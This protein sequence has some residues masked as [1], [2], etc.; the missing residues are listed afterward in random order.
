M[1]AWEKPET[2]EGDIDMGGSPM[3]AAEIVAMLV[4]ELALHGWE[5]ARSPGQVFAL[6][7]DTAVFLLDVVERYA[8]MYRRYEGF[9][10]VVDVPADAPAIDRALASARNLASPCAASA[11]ARTSSTDG[12]STTVSADTAINARS[13]PR[14]WGTPRATRPSRSRRRSP[15]LRPGGTRRSIQATC[16]CRRGCTTAL[17][18]QRRPC[19]SGM[20]ASAQRSSESRAHR[21]EQRLPVV[22]ARR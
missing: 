21:G 14:S 3:P 10:A 8:E 9:A 20:T 11:A 19:S 13:S 17:S 5:L 6:P 1:A 7:M 12:S 4:E 22:V 2:W 18:V 15:R 16:G